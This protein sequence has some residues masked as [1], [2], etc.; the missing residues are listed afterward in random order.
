MSDAIRSYLLSIVAVSLLTTLV[1]SC[2][3]EGGVRRVASAVCGLLLTLCALSP[4][5]TLDGDTIAQS[6]W[7]IQM[8]NETLRT[9][10]EV[11]NRQ[12]VSDIIKDKTR[13]YILDKAASMA[14]SLEVE[15]EMQD[16]GDY[17]YPY[18]VTLTGVITEAQRLQLTRYIEENLAIP[19]ERQVWN[20]P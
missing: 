11:K 12:L 10:V 6:I 16:G 19:A 13:T 17:P 14:L 1:R 20:E 7:R 4:L 8:E 3:P 18:R 9:G 15:V 2:I 5:V